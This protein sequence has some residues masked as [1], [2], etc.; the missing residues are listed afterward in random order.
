MSVPRPA[1]KL[2]YRDLVAWK[3]AVELV[4][5]VY[6]L[7]KSFPDDERYGLTAQLRRAAISVASNIAEGQGRF[8]RG[9]FKQFLGHA[10]GSLL[11][12]ETQM[13]IATNLGYLDSRQSGSRVRTLI[14]G[15]QDSQWPDQLS[16]H[17]SG[18]ELTTG[19]WQLAN[20]H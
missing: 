8:S 7:T 17:A 1:V 10:R 11:E 4:T 3:R 6:G 12:I 5:H 15:G 20:D 18:S 2:S 19:N 14:R 16:Q 13:T 9:E